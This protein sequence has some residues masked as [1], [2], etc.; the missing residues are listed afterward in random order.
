M[1]DMTLLAAAA[2]IFLA[3]GLV[4]GVIGFGMPT[5][6]IGLLGLLVAPAEAAALIVV[7]SFAT[8]LW[9][10]VV[11][12][13]L[14]ALAARLW[15]LLLAICLGTAAGFRLLSGMD[16]ARATLWLGGAL[17]AYAAIG[18]WSGRLR[19]PPWAERWIGPP[20]GIATGL[21]TSVTGLF[22]IPAVPFLQAIGLD[23]DELVQ[24]MGL[25]FT[26]STVALAAGL[27]LGGLLPPSVA[28]VSL[29]SLAPALAGMWL[30]QRLRGRISPP[31]FRFALFAG[32]LLLG[33]HLMWR[34]LS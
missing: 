29:V 17:V 10:A 8:N 5:V 7:P 24:A 11:G 23:R 31:A 20:A 21:V 1:H 25:S 28:G 15:P 3:A 6:G 32:L 12:G 19:L 18:L 14:R 34:G 22:V 13:R 2:A 30:G 9:Q 33:A 26:V 27:A 16:G 4:K